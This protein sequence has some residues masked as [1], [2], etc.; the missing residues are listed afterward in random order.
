MFVNNGV[1]F[2]MQ[3]PSFEIYKHYCGPQTIA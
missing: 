3:P 2:S 1:P